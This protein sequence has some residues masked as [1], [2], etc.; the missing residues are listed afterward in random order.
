MCAGTLKKDAAPDASEEALLLPGPPPH[1][2]PRHPIPP[3]NVWVNESG[4]WHPSTPTAPPPW[5]REQRRSPSHATLCFKWA[6]SWG[7]FGS[8][9]SAS[10]RAIGG[11]GSE[12]PTKGHAG[13]S[14]NPFLPTLRRGPGAK[15]CTD[16]QLPKFVREDVPLFRAMLGDLFPGVQP[17]GRGLEDFRVRG[18]PHTQ[19]IT[20]PINE[21]DRGSSVRLAGR[22]GQMGKIIRFPTDRHPWDPV[23][24]AG[25]PKELEKILRLGLKIQPPIPSPLVAR[26]TSLMLWRCVPRRRR[27]RRSWR[28]RGC[29]PRPT[30][31][32]SASSPR[33]RRHRRQGERDGGGW[34]EGI[35]V[36]LVGGHLRYK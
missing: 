22:G 32:S 2:T 13:R 5:T 24:V 1:P 12:A 6:V 26:G 21:I 16:M 28:A 19:P 29:S 15:A 30:P 36:S 8:G 31:S 20:D 11:R 25:E 4:H 17:D 33:S 34:W 3:P 23:A 10:H 9:A 7:L 14:C 18:R 35:A 27:W